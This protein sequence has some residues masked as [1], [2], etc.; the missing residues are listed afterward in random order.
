M[1]SKKPKAGGEGPASAIEAAVAG[2]G[3]DS[4]PR[5][6]PSFPVAPG[7]P[8]GH[9][10]PETPSGSE[11]VVEDRKVKAPGPFDGVEAIESN[12]A[13]LAEIQDPW[14]ER[15]QREVPTVVGTDSY[16]NK[17]LIPV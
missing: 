5:I 4:A 6:R 13:L 11:A 9:K 7:N 8:H 15:A 12:P 3:P 14:H 16:G 10:E 1:A 2:H 17:V